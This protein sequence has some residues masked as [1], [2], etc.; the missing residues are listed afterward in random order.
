MIK[1]ISNGLAGLAPH[2]AIIDE[3]APWMVETADQNKRDM[4]MAL[5]R[6]NGKPYATLEFMKRHGYI[7]GVDLANGSDYTSSGKDRLGEGVNEN[8]QA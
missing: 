8:G 6:K 2:T 5:G 7:T 3:R 4:I 1:P